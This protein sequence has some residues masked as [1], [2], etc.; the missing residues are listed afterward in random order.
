MNDRWSSFSGPAWYFNDSLGV[1]PARSANRS[2]GESEWL[3]VQ[4]KARKSCRYWPDQHDENARAVGVDASDA[5]PTQIQ[6][7]RLAQNRQ[8]R[9]SGLGPRA[10]FPRT[11]DGRFK[12][13]TIKALVRPASGT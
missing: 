11:S 10:G 1:M 8:A 4:V 3:P 6:S 5:A 13:D 12:R 7:I 9:T 2:W